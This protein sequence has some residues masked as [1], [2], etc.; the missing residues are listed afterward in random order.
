MQETP[1]TASQEDYIEAIYAIV[2]DRSVARVKDIAE[3]LQVHKSTVTAALHQLSDR[4][5]VNYAPY[6]AATLTAEGQRIGRTVLRRHETLKRFLVEVLGIDD[7]TAAETACK[8]EHVIPASVI[9][10][11]TRFAEYFES[12]PYASAQWRK[13]S[14]YSCKY[15]PDR[16][17]CSLCARRS[18]D[19]P[20]TQDTEPR[21]RM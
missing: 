4:K 9:E 21:A 5:L 12:C 3:R 13:G 17:E 11:F 16:E 2:L 20:Q 7:R 19:A 14:G 10:R 1:L 8:M 18:S 15:A 6:E